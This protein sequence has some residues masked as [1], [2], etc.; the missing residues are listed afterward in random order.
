MSAAKG[1]VTRSIK[2]L[3]ASCEEF[4]NRQDIPDRTK[5]RLATEILESRKKVEKNLAQME[6]VGEVLMDLI[7]KLDQ[8]EAAEDL[9]TMIAKVN[10][11]IELYMEK[12]YLFKKENM[13]TLETVD[14]L[15][16]PPE[17]TKKTVTSAESNDWLLADR[18]FAS[19]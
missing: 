1:L 2:K 19:L 6:E 16:K 4:S 11:D 15:L 3:E 18:V 9:E 12:F 8:K 17:N 7:A 14:R 5:N 13:G 10:E